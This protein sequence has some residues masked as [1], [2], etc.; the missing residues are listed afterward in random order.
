[1]RDKIC[2]ILIVKNEAV[3]I[4]RTLESVLPH[5]DYA[6][7]FDTGSE[8]NTWD[9]VNCCLNRFAGDSVVAKFKFTDFGDT[10]TRA[11][12]RAEE[13]L[14]DS[15]ARCHFLWLDGDS[16]LHGGEELRNHLCGLVAHEDGVPE[17]GFYIQT[18][19]GDLRYDMLRVL[20]A[21]TWDFQGVV[22]E[23][24]VLRRPTTSGLTARIPGPYV[25]YLPS[26]KPKRESWEQ[27]VKIL[28]NEVNSGRSG[29]REVFYLGQTLH[30]LERYRDAL[31]WYAYRANLSGSLEETFMAHYRAG[32]VAEL[33]GCHWHAAETWFIRAA[34]IDPRRA[35]PYYRI[36]KHYYDTREWA[37]CAVY[38]GLALQRPYPH[39]CCSWSQRFTSGELRI[40]TMS[41][42][43]NWI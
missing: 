12:R 5:V 40:C 39:E 8:D 20:A 1:M 43:E 19:L 15:G 34:L 17:D 23:L 28:L 25:E 11:M 24:P 13:M 33:A 6:F 27:H 38:A 2:L 22:H 18:H 30:C 31:N 26:S 35:E 32:Q 29:P 4:R 21:D 41:H 10:R 9:E 7:V 14:P 16:V 37:E 42:A 3:N 36:A